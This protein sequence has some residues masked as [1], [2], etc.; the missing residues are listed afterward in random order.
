MHHAQSFG[1]RG[2]FE[3]R[4]ALLGVQAE[5][6]RQNERQPQRIVIGGQQSA[7]FLRSVGLGQRQRFARQ[8]DQRALQRF[9]L[10]TLVFRQRQRHGAALQERL[11]AIHLQQRDALHAQ[12]HQFEMALAGTVHLAND[13]LGPDGIEIVLG[14]R[15]HVGIALGKDQ[16]FLGLGGERGLH[17]GDGRRA[18]G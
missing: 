9:N 18:S 10:R 15:I 7:Q 12:N 3:Q 5:H 16:N 17:R 2:R 8:F 11:R 1:S 6:G 14:G 4:L 13:G